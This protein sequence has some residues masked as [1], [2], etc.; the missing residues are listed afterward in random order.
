M[1]SLKKQATEIYGEERIKELS[2]MSKDQLLKE[3]LGDLI[4]LSF[5]AKQYSTL[6]CHV[7]NGILSKPMTKVDAV[8]KDLVQGGFDFDEEE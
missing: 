2:E 7:T 3:Y 1:E 4:D 8:I 5:V 6:L